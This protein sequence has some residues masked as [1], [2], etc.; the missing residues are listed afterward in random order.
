MVG[1]LQIGILAACLVVFVPMGMAGW[2]LSRNRLLFFSCALFITLAVS[3]HLTPYFPSVSDIVSS[4]SFA[5]ESRDSCA[6]FLNEIDWELGNEDAH[7]GPLEVPRNSSNNS[8][9]WSPSWGWSRSKSVVRCGFLKLGRLDAMELLNG[10]WIVVAGDSE[11]RLFVLSLLM[12]MLE[13]TSEIEGDLFKRHSDYHLVIEDHGVKVDFVW[14]PYVSNLTNVLK[15]FE[16]S[17]QYPDVLVMGSGLWHMLHYTNSSDYGLSL[18]LFRRLL[19]SL[20]PLTPEVG[21]DG[22]I[23]GSVSVKSP[24]MFWLG[25][26]TLIN[27]MLNTQEKREKMTDRACED[28]NREVGQSRLLKQ[29]GG[30][31][32]LL[33]V[34]SLTHNC[35]PGCTTDGMHYNKAIYEAAAQIMLNALIIQSQQSI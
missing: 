30:P 12:V 5:V 18:G 32:M 24:H 1:A 21:S 20:L 33:D 26:P 9:N 15:E 29:S 25:M 4:L 7:D 6:S 8:S 27:S 3:V 22:P 13:S 31:L 28:Y 34:G 14:A 11:A 19:D 16:I 10:S 17:H 23:S 35:G 2:H